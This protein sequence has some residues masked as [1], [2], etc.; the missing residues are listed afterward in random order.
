VSSGKKVIKDQT[1]GTYLWNTLYFE[2]IIVINRCFDQISYYFQEKDFRIRQSL[3]ERRNFFINS[4]LS[5]IF[6]CRMKSDFNKW[7]LYGIYSKTCLS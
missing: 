6:Y 1:F 4:F 3:L 5:N 7:F 2:A